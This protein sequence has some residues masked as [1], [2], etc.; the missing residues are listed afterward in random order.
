MGAALYSIAGAT[1]KNTA[2]AVG[3]IDR[4]Q[5]IDQA[6]ASKEEHAIKFTEACLREY[7]LNPK[8]VYLQ[9]AR[10]RLQRL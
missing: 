4:A 6:V 5:L 10:D 9:A 8:P 2:P 7:D 3:A 1:T